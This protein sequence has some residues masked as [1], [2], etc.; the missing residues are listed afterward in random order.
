MAADSTLDDF[1]Q[2]TNHVPTCFVKELTLQVLIPSMRN[3]DKTNRFTFISKDIRVDFF[4]KITLV[5]STLRLKLTLEDSFYDLGDTITVL[6]CCLEATAI[7]IGT[8]VK[9]S[10]FGSLSFDMQNFN[11]YSF[12]WDCI[13]KRDLMHNL[14]FFLYS[15][16]LYEE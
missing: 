13:T 5:D 9:L 12:G 10:S 3:H 15:R 14:G 2:P 8:L 11:I 7:W 6:S 1:L 4:L 16:V